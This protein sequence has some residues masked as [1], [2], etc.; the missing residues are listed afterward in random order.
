MSTIMTPISPGE[1]LDRLTILEIKLARIEDGGKRA[2][3]KVEFD[4]LCQ[5]VARHIPERADI[6]ALQ[7]RLKAVNEEL[8]RIEDNIRDC[9]RT[10]DF[11]STFVNLARSVYITNDTRAALKKDINL[12]LGSTLVEE[13][14]YAP[15]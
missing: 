10:G 9:E 2:N 15:Y 5:V 1:L 6:A 12:A 13:K 14:S 11:G 3:V 8:W 4:T 7:A